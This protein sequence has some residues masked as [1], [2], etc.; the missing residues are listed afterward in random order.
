MWIEIIRFGIALT[1]PVSRPARG[2]WIEIDKFMELIGTT[3]QSRPA[4]GVWIEI[5][6]CYI[7]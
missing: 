1:S 3:Q 5:D 6:K 2:V 7:L 4:R